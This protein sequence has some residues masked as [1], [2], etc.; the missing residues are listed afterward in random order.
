MSAVDTPSGGHGLSDT[1]HRYHTV[2]RGYALSGD[3]R[4]GVAGGRA[5]SLAGSQLVRP[6]ERLREHGLGITQQ[7]VH[8]T[9]G[10]E[11][12]HA[13][14]GTQHFR[15]TAICIAT[16]TGEILLRPQEGAYGSSFGG[17]TLGL[18]LPNESLRLTP[19]TL[20]PWLQCWANKSTCCR[21][22]TQMTC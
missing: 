9:G 10:K 19:Q 12:E 11:E 4:L 20:G 15:R 5:G 18:A 8:I 17:E 14:I 22:S 3:A 1:V 6:D 2:E 16:M 21:V 13:E 7:S